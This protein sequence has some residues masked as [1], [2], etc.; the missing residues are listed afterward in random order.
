MSLRMDVKKFS[1][2]MRCWFMSL[3]APIH[4]VMSVYPPPPNVGAVPMK[5]SMSDTSELLADR[6]DSLVA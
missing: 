1:L 3:I 6:F 4:S 2:W 5:V